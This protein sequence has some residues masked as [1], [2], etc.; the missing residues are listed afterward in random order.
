VTVYNYKSWCTVSVNG[1]A[2]SYPAPPTAGVA[3]ACVTAG[4]ESALVVAPLAGGTFALG[5]DPWLYIS[6]TGG[7]TT[8]ISGDITG[9]GGV[10]SSSAASV[11]VAAGTPGCVVVCCPFANGSGCSA[12]DLGSYVTTSCP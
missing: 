9:D 5:P 2:L 10:S 12:A 4:V 1:N 6:G 8:P 11:E 7:T 3:S